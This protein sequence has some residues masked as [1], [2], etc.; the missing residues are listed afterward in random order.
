M[1]HL[2]D[3]EN[4]AYYLAME[5]EFFEVDLPTLEMPQPVEGRYVPCF[6]VWLPE[7]SQEG[8]AL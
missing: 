8:R 5:R 1:Q 6:E 3:H 7:L 2:A 4:K